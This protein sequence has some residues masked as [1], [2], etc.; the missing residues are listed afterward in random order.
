[1]SQGL[2]KAE[3]QHVAQLA[4]LPLKEEE[5]VDFSQ[6]LSETIDYVKRLNEVKTT[7]V[8]PTYQTGG[9]QNRFR[10]DEITPSLP[11]TEALKNAE[12]QYNNFFVAP[13]V[14]D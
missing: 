5:V 3:V 8:A 9:T 4:N 7:A 13:D 2:T 10:E 11:P 14:W 1:M 12:R 6:K